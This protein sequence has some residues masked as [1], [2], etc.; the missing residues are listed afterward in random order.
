MKPLAAFGVPVFVLALAPAC[1]TPHS[2][3]F[4]TTARPV[5]AGAAELS[6]S[7]G[8]AYESANSAPAV[9]GN[10]TVTTNTRALGIPLSEANLEY[11]ATD[12]VGVNLHLSTAGVQP[13]VKFSFGSGDSS[14]QFALLP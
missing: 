5:G 3:A 2:L 13:G 4:G 9:N 14:T 8:I 1:I 11:G 6:V 7:P 12:T 10:T